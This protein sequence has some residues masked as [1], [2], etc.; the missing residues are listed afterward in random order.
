[1][2]NPPLIQATFQGLVGLLQPNDPNVPQ[3]P[4]GNALLTSNTGLYMQNIHPLA[5]LE[6][7]FYAAPDFTIYK[8]AAWISGAAYVANNVVNYTDG[9]LYKCILAVTGTTAPP[10]DATHWVLYRPF[11]DWLTQFYT[12]ASTNYIGE[13]VQRKK[14]LK[15]GKALIEKQEIY[16]GYGNQNNLI[17]GLGRAVGFELKPAPVDGLLMQIDQIGIQLSAVQTELNLYLYHSSQLAPITVFHVANIGRQNFDWQALS[18]CILGFKTHG[19]D[20]SGVYYLVYYEAD[21]TGQ[22]VAKTWDFTSAPCIGCDS[23]NA[24]AYNKWSKYT[25]IRTIEVAAQYLDPARNLFDINYISYNTNSNFGLNLTVTVRCDLTQRIVDTRLLFGDGFAKQLA[26]E[27]LK[28]IAYSG[29]INPYNDKVNKMAM[30]DLD[31]KI[32]GAYICEW[33]EAVDAANM[34]LTGFSQSCMPEDNT[35]NITWGSV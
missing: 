7:L 34:D 12:Q 26:Y 20:T 15:M 31:P 10:A 27:A 30:A 3:I 21:L 17:V 18:N 16:R 6:N 22:A 25:R 8:W 11:I 2:F 14:L 28:V 32:S 24:A 13:V 4:T 9:N 29:R 1:M 5:S 19:T 33:D 23:V 35:K